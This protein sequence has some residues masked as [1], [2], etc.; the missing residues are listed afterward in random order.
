MFLRSD[1]I[2]YWNVALQTEDLAAAYLFPSR[3]ELDSPILKYRI[4][5]HMAS[6]V[7][8]MN[9]AKTTSSS[10]STTAEAMPTRYYTYDSVHQ[11]DWV[12]ILDQSSSSTSSRDTRLNN[13]VSAKETLGKLDSG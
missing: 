5:S 10:A 2:G 6:V 9:L 7:E 4:T 8:K 11:N 13:E 3:T 1:L 12:E